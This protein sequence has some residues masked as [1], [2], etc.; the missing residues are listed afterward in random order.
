[1]GGFF[2]IPK[3]R[4]N[5][6]ERSNNGVPIRLD[7]Y[8][9]PWYNIGTMYIRTV[10]SR[11]KEYV[12]L[13]HNFR[14]PKTGV[15]KP[16]ILFNFGRKDQIDVEGLERF[17]DSIFRFWIQRTWQAYPTVEGKISP[18]SLS[19]LGNLAGLGY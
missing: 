9:T 1:M 11:N 10:K 14:D 5:R 6:K 18:S 8:G 7:K 4:K 12:Q 17:A 13:A 15:S 19:D 2:L 16:K 3:W